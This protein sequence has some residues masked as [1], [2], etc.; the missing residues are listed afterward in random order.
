VI[1]QTLR[2]ITVFCLGLVL[3]ALLGEH[4]ARNI[5]ADCEQLGKA[6]IHGKPFQCEP[7]RDNRKPASLSLYALNLAPAGSGMSF[8]KGQEGR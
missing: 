5:A 7:L 6:V 8:Y 4:E 1:I 3:H 2:Y